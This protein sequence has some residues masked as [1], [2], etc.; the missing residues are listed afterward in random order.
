MTANDVIK[1][2]QQHSKL[3]ELGIR[4]VELVIKTT[5]SNKR[6]ELDALVD[7]I[8]LKMHDIEAQLNALAN[9]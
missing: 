7:D 6:K 3:K 1:L 4:L 5:D 2:A 8:G 9:S